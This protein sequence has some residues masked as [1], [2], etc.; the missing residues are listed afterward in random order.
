MPL[1]V[2]TDYILNN[3]KVVVV[4]I[5]GNYTLMLIA[6]LNEFHRAESLRSQE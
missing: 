1:G 6:K 2:E 4:Y 5:R 3:F